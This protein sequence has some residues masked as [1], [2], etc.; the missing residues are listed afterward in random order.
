[1]RYSLALLCALKVEA[2]P[3]IESLKMEEQAHIF[4]PRLGLKFFVS[5][6]YSEIS[7]VLFGKCPT[8]TIDRI[9]TQIATLATWETIKTINPKSIASV[10]TAGGFRSKGTRIGDVF[11]SEGPIYFHGRHIP[12][13]KY[14]AFELGKFASMTL[15]T[16]NMDI[17]RGVVSSGDSIPISLEDQE[18]MNIIGT[19]AKD[20]EAAAVAE[21]AALAGV[22]MFAL[23]AISD[24]VDTAEQTHTQFLA[25]YPIAILN[26]AHTI[27]LLIQNNYLEP[28]I[29]SA[30]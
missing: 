28:A 1:M 2:E 15:N 22:P 24:F 21:V 16:L 14:H 7:M 3:I 19:D 4:D 30:Q 23:K 10:G 12:A 27:E 26:L 9:G 8:A 11:L 17:K 6:N 20:M 25:N 5:R 29:T 18:K 13:P